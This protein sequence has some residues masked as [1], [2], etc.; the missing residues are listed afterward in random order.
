MVS[1]LEEQK[2]NTEKPTAP[3][4]LQSRWV[5]V[6]LVLL[7]GTL[8]SLVYLPLLL[9]LGKTT[10]R[11]EQLSTGGLLVLFAIVI[12]MRD[13]LEKLRV[14]PN[15][16]NHGLG[17]LLAAFACLWLVGRWQHWTL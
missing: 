6:G 10:L 2:S 7:I 13:A 4:W 9:W 17:L 5:G 11:T 16:N 8:L 14:E 3:G 15:L 12:C 1:T